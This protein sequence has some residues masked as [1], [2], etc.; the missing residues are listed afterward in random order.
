MEAK[1]KPPLPRETLIHL[2]FGASLG[3]LIN[4]IGGGRGD[5]GWSET[6]AAP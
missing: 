4:Q 1:E 6:A 3:P 5:A 2:K